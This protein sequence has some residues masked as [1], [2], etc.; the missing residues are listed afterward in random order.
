MHM[1]GRFKIVILGMSQGRHPKDTFSGRFEDV[2][3]TFLQNCKN[4]QQLF[5]IITVY[6][7]KDEGGIG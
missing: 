7:L 4:K 1:Y 6:W 3:K 2:H 5:F